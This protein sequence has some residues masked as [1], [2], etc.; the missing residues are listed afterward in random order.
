MAH[1][2]ID[3]G[4]VRGWRRQRDPVEFHGADPTAPAQWVL[5]DDPVAGAV[6]AELDLEAV[7]RGGYAGVD[8]QPSASHP[9]AEDPLEA[10]AVHPARRSRVPGPA[11]AA[12]VR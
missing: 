9:E 4:D 7:P 5:D 6:M 2:V 12:D 3:Q 1:P 11:A 10:G 8:R